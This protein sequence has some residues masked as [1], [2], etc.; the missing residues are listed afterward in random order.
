MRSSALRSAPPPRQARL[1]KIKCPG[2]RHVLD[3]GLVLWFPGP[4]SFTGEDVAE[5]HLHGGPAVIAA[6]DPPPRRTRRPPPRRAGEFTRRA[7]ANG[8]LDL[9]EAEGL[10]DLIGAETEQQRRLALRQLA[11]K[12]RSLRTWRTDL[13]RALALLE[14][15]ST[16]STRDLPPDCAEAASAPPAAQPRSNTTSPTS[17]AARSCATASP[18]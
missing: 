11:A 7:F 18:S 2:R 16:S 6:H 1:R 5:I 12:R 9:T 4:A 8:K 3:R 13:V 10:A 15:R 17:A 14:A